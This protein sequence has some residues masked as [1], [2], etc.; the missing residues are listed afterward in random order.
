VILGAA[1]LPNPPVL[2][3]AVASGAAGEL[4][5]LRRASSEALLRVH[6]DGV[7]QL[8]V[9]GA[10]ETSAMH[11]PVARGSLSGYGVSLEVHLGS[12]GCGGAVELPLSLTVGAW[13]VEQALGPSSGAVGFSVGPDFASSRAAVELLAFAESAPLAL[14]VMGDGSARRST[15]AP[16]YQDPRAEPFDATVAAALRDGDGEALADLDDVLG[17]ELLAAGV[18]A[19]R[20]AGAL[21]AGGSYDAE[22]LY[23]QAPYGVGYFAAAWTARA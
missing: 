15:T 16:G 2:V 9:L 7:R 19:W 4:E 17:A 20:A 12:P 1:F 8:A 21:L 11:S 5:P 23:A 6:S 3:P 22:L 10:A 13:L 14:V 18:P